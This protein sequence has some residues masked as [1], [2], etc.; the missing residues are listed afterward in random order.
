MWT[1]IGDGDAY[2]FCISKSLECYEEFR[3]EFGD[4]TCYGLIQCDLSTPDRRKLYK[5]SGLR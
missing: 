2:E 4:V 1:E 5:G 3:K